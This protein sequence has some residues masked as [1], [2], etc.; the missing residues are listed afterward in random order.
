MLLINIFMLGLIGGS[1]TEKF[2]ET[3]ETIDVETKYGNIAVKVLKV[4][5]KD[6]YFV[7]RHGESHNIPPH[8]VNYHGNLKAL[9][10]LDVKKIIATNAV[11]S[12][13]KEYSIGSFLLP[14]TFVDFSKQI[15]TY[16]DEDVKHT[17]VTEP[18][19]EEMRKD[20]AEIGKKFGIEIYNG[21]TY[22]STAGPRY[23]TI[24]EIEFYRKMGWDV[25]GMT[26]APE[27]TLAN[28]LGMRYVSISIIT[29]YAAGLQKKVSHEEVEESMKKI[30]KNLK[31]IL[32]EYVKSKV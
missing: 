3:K 20:I 32:E 15:W 17:D 10:K 12:L 14:H 8:K 25:V 21:G 31:N 28:E 4:G 24:G 30:E 16:Y 27:T 7:H 2:F 18:Y 29:N 9:E 19:D 26:G 5:N 1:G 22:V 23:E 6:V 13:K 11:G